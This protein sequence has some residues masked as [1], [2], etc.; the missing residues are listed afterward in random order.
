M[1]GEFRFYGGTLG[2]WDTGRGMASRHRDS[3]AACT[4][5]EDTKIFALSPNIPSHQKNYIYKLLL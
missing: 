2:H 4:S 1:T 3:V 5:L